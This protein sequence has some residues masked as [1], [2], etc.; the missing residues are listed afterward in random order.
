MTEH[1]AE[2][3]HH[4]TE[5]VHH[6]GKGVGSA[7]GRKL[8]P[9][10]VGGWLLAV[11]GGVLVA[12]YFRRKATTDTTD[13]AAV[14]TTDATGADGFD[15]A[16]PGGTQ[17]GVGGGSYTYSDTATG[18]GNASAHHGQAYLARQAKSNAG[19]VD[20]SV[21]AMQARGFA[22]AHVRDALEAFL[23]GHTLTPAQEVAL[24]ATEALCGPPPHPPK[25]HPKPGGGAV[26]TPP[27]KPVHHPHHP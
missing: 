13:P 21:R 26:H 27:T 5:A 1:A 15:Q 9:M 8:G 22:P 6:A 11:G 19:W 17:A 23:H 3:A 2:A 12:V 18:N 25:H 10:P 7:L 20:H 16:D 14:D 4:T 24:A